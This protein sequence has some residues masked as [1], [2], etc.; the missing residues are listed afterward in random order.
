[1]YEKKLMDDLTTLI[2]GGCRSGKSRQALA[3][4]NA[5]QARCKWFMATC[6]PQDVEMLDRIQ[7]HQQERGPDW[8]T[9]EAP[10][11]IAHA[12]RQNAR[13][14]D[15]VLIDCLT[16][17]ASNMML[18]H[19]EDASIYHRIDELCALLTAPPCPVILV[20]NEVGT[21]IVPVNPL[22]RRY[23]DLIGRINQQTASASQRVIWMVAGIAVTI[24]SA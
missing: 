9:V 2:I 17:W 24:K 11:A 15:V 22:A 10:I 8:R 20:T 13:S 19:E 4:G 16:L 23:R 12:V 21:G 18:A 6:Q 3:L 14:G 7:R 1:V 5:V